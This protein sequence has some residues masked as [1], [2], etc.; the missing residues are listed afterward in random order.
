MTSFTHYKQFLFFTQVKCYRS[1]ASK[2]LQSERQQELKQGQCKGDG[3]SGKSYHKSTFLVDGACRRAVDRSSDTQWQTGVPIPPSR[4][5]KIRP[6]RCDQKAEYEAD[7]K[8]K[9]KEAQPET[10]VPQTHVIL[11]FL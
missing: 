2:I 9:R 3:K 8:I 6:E 10:A 7:K 11:I 5:L 1:Q 4:G